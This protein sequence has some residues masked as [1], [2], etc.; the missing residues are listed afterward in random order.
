LG[1]IAVFSGF[2]PVFQLLFHFCDCYS[3]FS[4]VIPGVLILIPGFFYF[5][6]WFL[7]FFIPGF[8]ILIPFS[9]FLSSG[10]SIYIPGFLLFLF[11]VFDFYS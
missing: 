7:I 3:V 9:S 10:L 2:I 8:S 6:S 4:V 1:F 11:L 5:Y